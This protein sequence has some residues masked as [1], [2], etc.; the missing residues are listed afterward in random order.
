MTETNFRALCEELV[1]LNDV[2]VD[3]WVL[4]WADVIRRTKAALAQPEPVALTESDVTE[5]F[6]RHMGEGSQVGFEN[7]IAE[8]LARYGTAAIEPVP[9]EPGVADHVTDDEGTRWDRT[10]DAALWAKAFCLICPEMASRE[11][12]MIV[13]F[14]NAIMAGC[15]HQAWKI[16]AELRPVPVSERLPGPEDLKDLYC[17]W[18]HEEIG[19]VLPHWVFASAEL[20]ENQYLAWLP[21]WALPMP[22][23]ANTIN[24]ED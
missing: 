12:V 11:D 16:D 4:K 8:A 9:P 21:H 22:T 14:A 18:W 6:Y 5:L 2:E 24:Q 23:P 3:G 7:A 13:W 10:T 17:W 15:D 1:C 20:A 19:D